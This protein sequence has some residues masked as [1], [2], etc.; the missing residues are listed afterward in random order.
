MQHAMPT[1]A[2]LSS[3]RSE[4]TC[5]LASSHILQLTS[6]DPDLSILSL[7]CLFFYCI[8]YVGVSG[9]ERFDEHLVFVSSARFYFHGSWLRLQADQQ[10]HQ[11]L[12]AWRCQGTFFCIINSVSRDTLR[13]FLNF[14]LCMTGKP[15]T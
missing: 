2:W 12:H 8:V 13:V 3:S 15:Q 6:S 4:M 14:N 5:R 9:V 10:L 7:F 11:L 1:T